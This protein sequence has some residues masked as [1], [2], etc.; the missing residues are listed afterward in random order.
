MWTYAATAIA[1]WARCNRAASSFERCRFGN[2]R[3]NKQRSGIGIAASFF[4]WFARRWASCSISRCGRVSIPVLFHEPS[5]RFLGKRFSS[6]A[7]RN[8][9][10]RLY[11]CWRT[12]PLAWHL[13][14][15]VNN[16]AYLCC[17]CEETDSMMR[18]FDVDLSRQ[19]SW[20]L[21]IHECPSSWSDKKLLSTCSMAFCSL[22]SL[23]RSDSQRSATLLCRSYFCTSAFLTVLKRKELLLL[24][25][26]ARRGSIDGMAAFGTR[27]GSR[28]SAD[29]PDQMQMTHLMQDFLPFHP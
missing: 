29:G 24:L 15:S 19:S 16:V 12:R 4:S 20:P 21:Y 22:F 8:H 11:P 27:C 9:K 18:Q 2:W 14:P 10:G 23:R 28:L 25:F 17:I 13:L 1:Y 7:K 6:N 5:R 26:G 3:L